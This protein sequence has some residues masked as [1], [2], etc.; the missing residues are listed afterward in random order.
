M[1]WRS[2]QFFFLSSFHG[3]KKIFPPTCFLTFHQ[4]K[5]HWQHADPIKNARTQQRSNFE[6]HWSDRSPGN[7]QLT[8]LR[9]YLAFFP[10][11]HLRVRD[12]WFGKVASQVT[13]HLAPS[14]CHCYTWRALKVQVGNTAKLTW[15]LSTSQASGCFALI[16]IE[17]VE[18]I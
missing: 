17:F 15:K 14:S 16:F 3:W 13:W 11:S 4:I 9:Q 8:V 6:F 18:S 12:P 2:Q 10:P 7:K 1:P 5:F